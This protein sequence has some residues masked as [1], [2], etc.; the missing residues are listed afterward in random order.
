M[1]L[2][3]KYNSKLPIRVVFGTP[4]TTETGNIERTRW[5]A[6]GAKGV[7][8]TTG[9]VDEHSRADGSIR[10]D[11]FSTADGSSGGEYGA[12]RMTRRRRIVVF[13][14]AETK[15]STTNLAIIVIV[16]RRCRRPIERALGR[17]RRSRRAFASA[18]TSRFRR[19][20]FRSRRRTASRGEVSPERVRVR[21]GSVFRHR[22]RPS[23]RPTRRVLRLSVV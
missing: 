10:G 15:A 2:V 17:L 21:T 18:P 5:T 19:F 11:V 22:S 13:I 23:I 4:G 16:T 20:L 8:A 3:L 7:D 6:S 1:S 12:H 14:G 9:G